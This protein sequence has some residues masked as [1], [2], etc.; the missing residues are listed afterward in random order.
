[1]G[2]S[3]HDPTPSSL[4]ELLA[5]AEREGLTGRYQAKQTGHLWLARVMVMDGVYT[6]SGSCRRAALNRAAEAALEAAEKLGL[7]PH[8]RGPLD[9]HR[10]PDMPSGERPSAP[11]ALRSR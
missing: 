5:F 4:R 7:D 9:H 8:R 1:M 3:H 10:S 2:Q 11:A 6:G